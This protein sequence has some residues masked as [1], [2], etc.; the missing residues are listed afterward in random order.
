MQ[1]LFITNEMYVKTRVSSE[2]ES[3]TA[4]EQSL[5]SLLH[6]AEEPRFTIAFFLTVSNVFYRDNQLTII[7]T[8]RLGTY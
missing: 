7:F 4:F 8:H 1:Q 6:D 3:D 5:P 2:Q